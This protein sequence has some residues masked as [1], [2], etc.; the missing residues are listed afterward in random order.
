[1]VLSQLFQRLLNLRR[2]SLVHGDDSGDLIGAKVFAVLG[3]ERKKKPEHMCLGD[4][5]QEMF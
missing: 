4:A 5:V 1:M 3:V 2:P